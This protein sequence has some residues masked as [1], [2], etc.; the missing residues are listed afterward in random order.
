MEVLRRLLLRLCP[1]NPEYIQQATIGFYLS[2]VIGNY[3]M[4]CVF[5]TMVIFHLCRK[6]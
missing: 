3:W 5:L 1:I 4:L 6:S 2:W